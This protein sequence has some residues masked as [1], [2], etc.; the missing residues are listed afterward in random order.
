ML[1]YQNKWRESIDEVNIRGG[2]NGLKTRR[3]P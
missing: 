3:I 1:K 2:I